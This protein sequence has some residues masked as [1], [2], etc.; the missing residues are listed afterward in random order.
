MIKSHEMI[1]KVSFKFDYYLILMPRIYS[2]CRK[3]LCLNLILFSSM[4]FC[5][6]AEAHDRLPKSSPEPNAASVVATIY[7]YSPQALQ[8]SYRIPESCKALN[9]TNSD[10]TPQAAINMR[11]DWAAV[12]GCTKLN[13]QGVRPSGAECRVLRVH[14]PA[15][16]RVKSGRVYHGVQ[17]W[18]QPFGDGLYVH[19][20]AYEVDDSC[21]PVKWEVEARR[22]SVMIDGAVSDEKM[23]FMTAGT[24]QAGLP[25]LLLT[26]PYSPDA[27]LLHADLALGEATRSMFERTSVRMQDM[28]RTMLP[29]LPIRRGYM[30]AAASDE[31]TTLDSVKVSEH[32]LLLR[33][34]L[35]RTHDLE[36]KARVLIGH[37]A[38]HQ[39]HPARWN[40]VR[41]RDL[42]SIREG[43]AELLRLAASVRLGWLN[44]DGLKDELEAAVNSCLVNAGGKTWNAFDQRNSG[45]T[46]V[47][48]GLMLHLL[49]VAGG[50]KHLTALTR[51]EEFYKVAR[52]GTLVDFAHAIECGAETACVARRLLRI[53][54]KEPLET[55][56]QEEMHTSGSLLHAQPAWGPALVKVMVFRHLEQLLRED[57]RP[58]ATI[59]HDGTAPRI[60]PGALC[61]TFR[62]GMVLASAEGLPLFS[63][64][65]AIRSSARACHRSGV[66]V[67]GLNNGK[68]IMVPC[69]PSVTLPST[70][71]G[72]DSQKAMQMAWGSRTFTSKYQLDNQF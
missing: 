32:V 21:G 39:A 29:T 46:A 15:T 18:A 71:W 3:V 37:E 66:T 57:C 36:A 4:I 50:D 35:L 1:L 45:S 62:S 12:D 25:A 9:F 47:H 52:T 20:G 7:M 41:N 26:K 19:T 44:T 63:S 59:S 60:G 5:S 24:A 6:G 65:S 8:I 2:C 13:F 53:M 56:L 11:D 67:L 54:D 23:S 70:V 14:V 40:D 22:G 51:L 68:R 61:T 69:G 38:S 72:V 16:S 55:I 27:P 33:V 30:L 64:V 43:G 49:G 34:P 48:C 10:I 31:V 17:P 28:L 42:H 58:D